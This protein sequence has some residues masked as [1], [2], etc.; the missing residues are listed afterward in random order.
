MPSITYSD[1]DNQPGN[2]VFID[3]TNQMVEQMRRQ[4][5]AQLSEPPPNGRAVRDPSYAY[6]VLDRVYIGY[7]LAKLKAAENR[8]NGVVEGHVVDENDSR[9]WLSNTTNSIWEGNAVTPPD[10]APLTF[11]RLREAVRDMQNERLT[12]NNNTEE[13]VLPVHPRY[14]SLDPGIGGS[15]ISYDSLMRGIFPGE[16][17]T[18]ADQ[19]VGGITGVPTAI[20]GGTPATDVT[21]SGSTL[22]AVDPRAVPPE[23]GPVIRWTNG[24]EAFFSNDNIQVLHDEEAPF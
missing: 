19:F 17:I 22:S 18:T 4:A 5:N 23:A 11:D 6:A 9:I 15:I 21:I 16:A 20:L 24:G 3:A 8:L 10:A 13:F 2:N 14:V 12:I 7:P 1:N